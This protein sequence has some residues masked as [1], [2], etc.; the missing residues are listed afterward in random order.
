MTWSGTGK[1]A[2][3]AGVLAAALALPALAAQKDCPVQDAALKR[4][5]DR[6][7]MTCGKCSRTTCG[8]DVTVRW[9]M[10]KPGATSQK[11]PVLVFL[12]G[13]GEL[14][15]D[16]SR[17]FRN[18]GIFDLV[19][20]PG[21]QKRHPCVFVALQTETGVERH[22]LAK[23][24]VAPS[25]AAMSAALDEALSK[26]GN[27][28]I[29]RDRIYLTGLSAGGG[30]CC[31]M[32]CAYPGRFAAAFPIAGLICPK[33]LSDTV[34]ENIYLMYNSAE[35]A[36]MRKYVDFDSLSREMAARGGD[37]RVGELTGK[38]HNAWDAAWREEAAWNWLFSKRA[39]APA[40]AAGQPAKQASR[41]EWK[42][43]ASVS[44]ESDGTQ[45]RFGADGLAG[46]AFRSVSSAKKGD[47]WQVE[48]PAPTRGSI[49]IVTGDELGRFKVARGS[50][51][52]SSDGEHWSKAVAVRDGAAS[53]RADRS[54]RFVRL[55]V[56]A[57]QSSPLAVRELELR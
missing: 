25:L 51:M 1:K 46:T 28:R 22:Y 45:P 18:R 30:A 50:A 54:I 12:P 52:V 36:R 48:F 2:F 49:K 56:D 10:F 20:S 57:N 16:L 8:E 21:F 47:W 13:L 7:K 53:L 32:V 37:I 9:T 42:C 35:L 23:G 44:P 40:V 4:E 55:T 33:L 19:T 41:A 11:L 3:V 38:G 29:D 24:C 39:R 6:Y 31:S 15:P 14:G 34:P 26:A 5:L 27:V 43:S 17:L